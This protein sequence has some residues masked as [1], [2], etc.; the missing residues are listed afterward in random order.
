VQ[1]GDHPAGANPLRP[2]ALVIFGAGGPLTA[3]LE[4]SCGRLGVRIAACVQNRPG[5]VFTLDSARLVAAAGLPASLAAVPFLCPLFT[6]TNRRTAV[7]EAIA[8]GLS[9]AAALA[10]PTAVVAHSAGLG[11]GSWISAGCLLGAALR[12][13]RHVLVNRGAS[14]AH[15]VVVGDFVSIGPG[16]IV[17]GQAEIGPGTLIG[18]GAVVAPGIRIG[19]E[20]VLAP[21]A[22][23]WRDMPAGH[24]ALGNPATIRRRPR[25]RQP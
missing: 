3:E 23:V 20:C 19:A 18:V 5:P 21:G 15:H 25:P 16:A 12:L 8:L 10:D 4:E 6:P 1:D 2:L 17:A 13:G 22:V 24:I 7:A 9:P 11:Q 14:L